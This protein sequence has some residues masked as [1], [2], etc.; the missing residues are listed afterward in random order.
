M[1][2]SDRVPD[3]VRKECL[4]IREGLQD[5]R[6]SQNTPAEIEYIVI[7]SNIEMFS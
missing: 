5:D 4:E 3:E 1:T 6:F 2:D 7:V